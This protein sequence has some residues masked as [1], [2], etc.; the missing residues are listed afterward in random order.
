MTDQ[1]A[2]KRRKPTQGI[3]FPDVDLLERAKLRAKSMRLSLSQY[4]N[5]LVARD[6]GS[7]SIFEHIP[8]QAPPAKPAH[9][10]SNESDPYLLPQS[11]VKFESYR[12]PG[13]KLQE[14]RKRLREEE[15]PSSI[16]EKWNIPET[17]AAKLLTNPKTPD[18]YSCTIPQL[19]RRNQL[20][21]EE[22]LEFYNSLRKNAE[23]FDRNTKA[24]GEEKA[25]AQPS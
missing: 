22:A 9:A 6:L 8:M 4:I 20:T 25:S 19:M 14:F 7:P 5:H 23:V 1:T 15:T 12:L 2:K 18:E 13:E 17:L 21:R 16:A 11:Y 24:L 3:S 10:E